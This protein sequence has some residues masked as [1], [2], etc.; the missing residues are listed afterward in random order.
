MTRTN[1]ISL[2]GRQVN[3]ARKPI[4]KLA[5]PCGKSC[6]RLINEVVKMFAHRFP[7][8]PLSFVVSWMI[9]FVNNG[10]I[11]FSLTTLGYKANQ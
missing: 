9:G 8:L 11:S 2:S 4:L 7:G 5:S 1:N 6:Q 3:K 10:C